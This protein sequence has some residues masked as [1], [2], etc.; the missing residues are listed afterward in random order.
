MGSH[1][2]YSISS[3]LGTFLFSLSAQPVQAVEKCTAQ[4]DAGTAT[5]RVSA[6][7]VDGDLFWGRIEGFE[8]SGFVDSSCVSK[9]KANECVLS[10]TGATPLTHMD[11]CLIYLADDTGSCTAYIDGCAATGGQLPL[12][13]DDFEGEANEWSPAATSQISG[14]TVLGGYCNA[15]SNYT[16]TFDVSAPH[17][18]LRIRASAHFLDDWQSETAFLKVDGNFAW[19]RSHDAIGPGTDFAGNPAFGDRLS[20]LVDVIVPHSADTASVEFGSTLGV[21]SC[22]ASLAVDDILIATF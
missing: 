16:R 12:Y 6:R 8:A 7:K 17:T 1:L 22:E 20:E 11:Q 18:H 13:F 15:G 10:G 21:D 5:V 4:T 3:L 2:R 9:G 14:S 19:T